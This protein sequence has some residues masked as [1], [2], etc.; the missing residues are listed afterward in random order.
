MDVSKGIRTTGAAGRKHV[1]AGDQPTR[2]K[3]AASGTPKSAAGKSAAAAKLRKKPMRRPRHGTPSR[4]RGTLH[5]ADMVRPVAPSSQAPLRDLVT[6]QGL[7]VTIDL[8]KRSVTVA[9]ESLDTMRLLI[10]TLDACPDGQLVSDQ[11]TTELTSQEA[12]DLLNVSR[13][14]VVKLAREGRIAHRLVGNRHRFLLSDVLAYERGQ[15]LEREQAL[16]ALAPDDG[17]VDGDF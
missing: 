16:T 12:A 11:R 15:R 3:A 5:E 4:G 17:Y 7:K 8:G 2:I 9:C 6:K 10:A 14:Y 13:P 1:L